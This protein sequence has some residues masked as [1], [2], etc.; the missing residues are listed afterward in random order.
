MAVSIQRTD[1]VCGAPTVSAFAK[2]PSLEG[3]LD[4]KLLQVGRLEPLLLDFFQVGV[5]A[6]YS[7]PGGKA[8]R[9]EATGRG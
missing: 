7:P 3:V 9:G 1:G 2:L 6:V 5:P 4:V 8:R